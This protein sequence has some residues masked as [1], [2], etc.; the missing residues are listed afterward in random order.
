MRNIVVRGASTCV[1]LVLLVALGTASCRSRGVE[2]S[3]TVAMER[4]EPPANPP[5]APAPSELPPLVRK[6]IAAA[7]VTAP[8][9]APAPAPTAP[10]AGLRFVHLPHSAASIAATEVT[11]AQFRACVT[12]GVCQADT[13]RACNYDAEGKDAHPMNCVDYH[14]AEQMCGFA[15]AR[16]CT[17]PEWLEAC[18][19]FERR[20][21][22]YGDTFDLAACNSQ[23]KEMVVPD[24]ARGTVPVGSLPGCEGGLVGLFDMA[25]NVAEW[26]GGC[27]GTYCKFRGA[28]YF[29]NDP[30]DRFAACRG[31]CAG[32]QV[33]F[34]S[35]TIGI[36]CCRAET[37]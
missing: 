32:N 25:G 30:V 36:R 11:V 23:S 33:D 10:D 1:A 24:R 26:V 31:V 19:G 16:V 12:A 3:T 34:R 9:P 8:P 7:P 6:E 28:G 13:F 21:F 37:E 22:P 29:G 35:P 14:G 4:A 18:G 17:E 2:E 5:L 20:P 27:K 15:G